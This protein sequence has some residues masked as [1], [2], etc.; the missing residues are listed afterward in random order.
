MEIIELRPDALLRL[1]PEDPP[2]RLRSLFLDA[3]LLTTLAEPPSDG[4]P[5]ASLQAARDRLFE[6][7]ALDQQLREANAPVG[8]FGTQAPLW[9]WFVVPGVFV[10]TWRL[11]AC[12]DGVEQ[13]Q[14]AFAYGLM[15]AAVIAVLALAYIGRLELLARNERAQR[16][17]S[18]ERCIRAARS[19]LLPAVQVAVSRSYVAHAGARLVVSTPHLAWLKGCADAARRAVRPQS[20]SAGALEALAAELEAEAAAIEAL[21]RAL[22][23]QPR[24]G[25]T[26][27]GLQPDLEKHRARLADL[28]VQPPALCAVLD[29]AWK[30]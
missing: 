29:D 14:M 1:D 28:G 10:L 17:A 3:G 24:K 5:L 15:A 13:E 19:Q 22:V 4:S 6:L 12:G 25:W 18:T 21:V 7:I 27:E 26:N 23:D 2:E 9:T 16:I 8:G 30:A 11:S 20:D